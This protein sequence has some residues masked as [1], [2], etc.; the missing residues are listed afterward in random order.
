MAKKY[1]TTIEGKEVEVEITDEE[2]LKQFTQDELIERVDF[3]DKGK[4]KT[5]L[6]KLGISIKESKDEKKV[7]KTDE[8]DKGNGKVSDLEALKEALKPITDGFDK[9]E[10]RFEELEKKTA[11][12]EKEQS[13]KKLE[14]LLSDAVSEG[15]IAKGEVDTWKKKFEEKYEGRLDLFEETVQ[16]R[17][18]D[19][20]LKSDNQSESGLNKDKTDAPAGVPTFKTSEIAA[21]T[22]KEYNE[23][24]K[25]IEVAYKAG[26]VIKDT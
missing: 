9:I 16:Q 21:M 7:E 15:R 22:P 26:S 5:F 17:P 24:R 4:L 2:I 8:T 10:K 11:L 23:K 6:E 3:K 20:K 18:A 12:T 1:T 13:A 14:K 25:D 19:P